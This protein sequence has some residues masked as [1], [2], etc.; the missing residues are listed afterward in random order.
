MVV[1][2]NTCLKVASPPPLQKQTNKKTR[3]TSK[4]S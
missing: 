2:P 3:E 1:S 4:N